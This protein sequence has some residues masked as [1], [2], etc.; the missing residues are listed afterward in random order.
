MVIPVKSKTKILEFLKLPPENTNKSYNILFK[1]CYRLLKR[2]NLL[3]RVATHLKQSIA[4]NAEKMIWT[5][6]T[7]VINKS[8][9]CHIEDQYECIGYVD[10]TRIY[11]NMT[12][13]KQFLKFELKKFS[14]PH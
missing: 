9:I 1:W 2:H 12:T 4:D 5:F 7:Y 3:F 13:K 6:L 14:S 10:Q 8:K 11:L